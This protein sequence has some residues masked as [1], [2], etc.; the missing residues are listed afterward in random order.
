MGRGLEYSCFNYFPAV[1]RAQTN[2]TSTQIHMTINKRIKRN[3]LTQL[4]LRRKIV[5]SP[6]SGLGPSFIAN[7]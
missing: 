6:D 1:T 3:G 4:S 2:A 5:V 7:Q